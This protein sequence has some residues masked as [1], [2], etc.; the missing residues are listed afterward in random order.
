VDQPSGRSL[1][2]AFRDA[3]GFG[4]FAIAD[5]HRFVLAL[6]FR[7]KP[8]IHEVAYWSSVMPDQVPHQ[9]VENIFIQLDHAIPTSNIAIS[10]TL[11]NRD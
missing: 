6:L 3:H 1:C 9:A 10:H 8:Q 5:T 2:G 11:H 7:S 4:E